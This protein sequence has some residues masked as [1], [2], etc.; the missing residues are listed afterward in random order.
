MNFKNIYRNVIADRNLEDNIPLFLNNVVDKYY[1]YSSVQLALLYYTY[2]EMYCDDS[3]L[4]D[5]GL[6]EYSKSLNSIIAEN[7]NISKNGKD[8][9]DYVKNLDK[10]REKVKKKM[11][12]ITSYRDLFEIY[13]YTLNRVE[14]RFKSIEDI[15]EIEDD[16]EFAKIVLR[17]IFDSDDNVQINEFIKEVIGQLPIRI[18]RQKFFDYLRDG[19]YELNG[20]E[21]DT[22]DTYIY[23]IRSR[24]TL[25]I[26]DNIKG[27]Y[28]QLWSKKEDL[29]KLDFKKITQKDYDDTSASLEEIG[30]FIDTISTA[31]YVLMEIINKLYASLICSPY[32]N[33]V[34]NEYKE[35]ETAAIY[36]I[37]NINKVFYEDETGEPSEDILNK[38]ELL[39]GY[40]ENMDYDLMSFDDGISHI[41]T[42]H[43][44]LVESLMEEKLLNVLLTSKDLL[45]ASI[46]IDLKKE[47]EVKLVDK[48]KIQKE[49]DKLIEDLDNKFKN[50]DRMIV[51][52][53]M[54]N[55]INR[56]PVFFKNHTE[57]MD[58]VLYSLNKCTDKAEKYACKDIIN[59]MMIY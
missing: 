10:L 13:E 8:L 21:E 25:D 58:Y 26:T 15:D 44:D 56:L 36:I 33:T 34:S 1:T 47:K 27:E 11:D 16:E 37:D 4:W 52:A 17:Y 43:R 35:Q 5:D 59:D 29:E 39:E 7:I 20:V 54:A 46:F 28:P 45:S 18:T 6:L 23:I 41:N 14:Y 57:V 49:I 30:L 50:T 40:Q 24:A 42:Y 38:F 55:T 53:I 19:L 32:A 48:D 12:V 2:Y 3:K 31:Y 22:L 51:R 9:E